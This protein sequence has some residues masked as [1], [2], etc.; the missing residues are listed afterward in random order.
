[1]D[2]SIKS[3]KKEKK[4]KK[5]VFGRFPKAE[6]GGKKQRYVLA[7]S[8][9]WYEAFNSGPFPNFIPTLF[10]RRARFVMFHSLYC[11]LPFL[12]QAIT[13]FFFL[14]CVVIVYLQILQQK[15]TL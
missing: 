10:L 5:E 6:M 3:L 13:K 8:I 7:E 11:P 9:V 15:H 2:A 14:V 4:K 12:S 1:M